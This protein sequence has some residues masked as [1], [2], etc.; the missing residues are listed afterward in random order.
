MKQNLP[1]NNVADDIAIQ[2][3]RHN[4]ATCNHKMIVVRRRGLELS[5]DRCGAKVLYTWRQL[6]ALWMM[7]E[8]EA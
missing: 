8:Q 2:E 3:I 4:P 5:C 7:A 1:H 6:L